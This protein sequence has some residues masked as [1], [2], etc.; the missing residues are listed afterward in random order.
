[1]FRFQHYRRCKLPRFLYPVQ[2]RLSEVSAMVSL[3]VAGYRLRPFGNGMHF[4]SQHRPPPPYSILVQ[5][6]PS[7]FPAVSHLSLSNGIYVAGWPSTDISFGNHCH[8]AAPTAFI[9]SF[10]LGATLSFSSRIHCS[11][12]ASAPASLCIRKH[13]QQAGFW[14]IFHVILFARHF[15]H[16]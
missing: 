7:S 15:C 1:M 6:P 5:N 8:P 14:R 16:R 10:Q 13:F 2:Q 12:V 4:F 11:I 3:P 9:A